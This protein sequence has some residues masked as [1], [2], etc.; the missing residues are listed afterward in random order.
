M[1]HGP[2]MHL[3]LL[4][5]VAIGIVGWLA[6]LTVRRLKNRDRSDRD[7]AIDPNADGSGRSP[8]P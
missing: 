2:Q 7:R 1:E 8:E 3:I 5:V 4:P 6:Y